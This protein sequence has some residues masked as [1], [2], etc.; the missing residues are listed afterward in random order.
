MTVIYENGIH[1]A[2]IL[3]I[4]SSP[5]SLVLAENLNISSK[6]GTSPKIWNC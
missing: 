1:R 2:S 4:M 6:N 5:Y 3:V